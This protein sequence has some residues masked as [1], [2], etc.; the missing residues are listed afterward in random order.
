MKKLEKAIENMKKLSNE[1]LIFKWHNYI[2]TYDMSSENQ[3]AYA[4]AMKDEILK[5]MK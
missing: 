2:S 1:E 4:D 3:Q 5:R